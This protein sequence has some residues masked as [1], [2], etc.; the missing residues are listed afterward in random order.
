MSPR[1]PV[2]LLEFNE[3]TPALMDRFIADGKL[4]NFARLRASSDTFISDAEEQEP[5]LEPWIQW[6]TVHTGVPFSEHGIFRLSVAPTLLDLLGV[7]KPEHM[8]GESLLRNPTG[9]PVSSQNADIAA[10]A[11]R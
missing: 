11:P 3:L 8:K 7:D 2:V 9:K 4:P 6:V 5:Y 10:H 1:A